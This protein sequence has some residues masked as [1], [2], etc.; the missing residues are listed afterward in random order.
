MTGNKLKYG[1]EHQTQFKTCRIKK[2]TLCRKESYNERSAQNKWQ[3]LSYTHTHTHTYRRT[4]LF[5]NH[6]S[7][8]NI[9]HTLIVGMCSHHAIYLAFEFAYTQSHPY[10]LWLMV[11]VVV[12]IVDVFV[13]CHVLVF[14]VWLH[15]TERA[16]Y[17]T[18][19]LR[20]VLE[21][22]TFTIL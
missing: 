22:W 15:Q 1:S 13:S 3:P 9:W 8:E 6:N 20:I 5:S 10:S 2:K 7:N 16:R 4:Q 17:R 21:F 18:V 19:K 14:V 12:V 11:D